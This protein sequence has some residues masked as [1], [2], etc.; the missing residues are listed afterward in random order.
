MRPRPDVAR[1]A[2]MMEM[3]GRTVTVDELRGLGLYNYGHFTSMRVEDMRVRGLAL[4]MERLARDAGTLFGADLDTG[5]VLHLTR[6]FAARI[7][8][9]AI[10]RV[11]VFDSA[12]DM[13]R[14]GATSQPDILVSAR[15]APTGIPAPLRVESVQYQREMPSVKHVGLFGPLA[16]RRAAQLRGFDDALF[17]DDHSRVSEGPTWNIGFFDGTHVIWPKADVLVGVTLSLV[18][19]LVTGSGMNSMEC[20]VHISQVSET[21]T[22]FATN[23]SVGIRPVQ[24]IDSVELVDE[25]PI[26]RNLQLQYAAIPGEPL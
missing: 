12:A 9:P 13:N 24:S 18:K 23:A 20:I 2:C 3:N 21:W 16:H 15:H 14:P 4:H 8:S 1:L 7:D 17:V 5:R 11:T 22:A 26:V 10:V 6:S 25:S 19:N